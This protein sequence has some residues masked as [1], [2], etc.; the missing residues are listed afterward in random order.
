M[1]VALAA[2]RSRVQ[3]KTAGE[4][5]DVGEEGE[6]SHDDVESDEEERDIEQDIW[7]SEDL[8]AS[9]SEERVGDSEVSTSESEKQVVE[10]RNESEREVVEER[11]EGGGDEVPRRCLITELPD[12]VDEIQLTDTGKDKVIGTLTVEIHPSPLACS[13]PVY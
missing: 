11:S 2:L 5:E 7:A 4:T 1:F 9:A 12:T 6:D 10:E 13:Q 3:G 8:M